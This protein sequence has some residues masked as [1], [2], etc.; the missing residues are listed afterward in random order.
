MPEERLRMEIDE[1]NLDREWREHPQVFYNWA[2][3]AADA[4]AAFEEAKVALEVAKAE[5]GQEV[6]ENPQLYNME[7][8]TEGG[9]KTA[10]ELHPE[11]RLAQKVLIKARHERDLHD[12][13][14][15][16]LEHRKRALTK[17][18]DLWAQDYYS[19]NGPKPK[20]GEDREDWE[21]RAVRNRG[22]RRREAVEDGEPDDD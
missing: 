19:D 10:V 22:R 5:I 13:A 6:R 4:S 3:K 16:A 21:K 1:N 9:I 7:R 8:T 15:T 12:A 2:R 18:A 14:V 20:P 17:L 11:V